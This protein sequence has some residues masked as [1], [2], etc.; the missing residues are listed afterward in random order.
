MPSET[1][2][3]IVN[4]LKVLETKEVKPLKRRHDNMPL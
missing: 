3:R 4:A 2:A 1:R